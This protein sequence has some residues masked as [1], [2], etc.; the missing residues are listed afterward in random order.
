MFL[1]DELQ[2]NAVWSAFGSADA[3]CTDESIPDQPND[4][5]PMNYFLRSATKGGVS[6]WRNGSYSVGNQS[7]VNG[8]R[9]AFYLNES[10]VKGVTGSGTAADPYV[11]TGATDY[12]PVQL[13]GKPVSFDVQPMIENDRVLVP[14]RA[15]FEALGARI[16]WTEETQTVTAS[17]NYKQISLQIGS[18]E[19]YVNSKVVLLDVP[20][21]VVNGRTMVPIRAVSEGM[22]AKVE[23]DKTSNTVLITAPK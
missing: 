2:L 16:T 4:G 20:A 9:P 13:N 7:G 11:L 3:M 19:M 5:R 6:M 12:I 21:Q 8:I 18:R 17:G 14:M 23:W 15:I 22:G 10:A 1:L